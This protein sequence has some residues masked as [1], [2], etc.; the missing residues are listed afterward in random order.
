M[1]RHNLLNN[2]VVRANDIQAPDGVECEHAGECAGHHFS[3]GNSIVDAMAELDITGNVIP[4]TWFQSIK[5]DNGKPNI[6]ACLILSEIVYWYRPKVIFDKAS[7]KK[8]GIEKRFNADLLQKSYDDFAVKFGLSKDQARNAVQALEKK[9]II[10]KDFRTINWGGTKVANVLFIELFVD[11]LIEVTYPNG[12][13]S[14]NR[15]R[16]LGDDGEGIALKEDTYLLQTGYPYDSVPK[17]VSS[18]AHTNTK[19]TAEINTKIT[20]TTEGTVNPS[21]II[22]EDVVVAFAEELGEFRLDDNSIRAIIRAADG[23]PERVKKAIAL[24]KEQSQPIRNIPGWLIRA[25][26]EGYT[27][28]CRRQNKFGM[29]H[30]FSEKALSEIEKKLLT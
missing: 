20:T 7:G 9:G 17:G 12:I 6:N 28:V 30:C 8:T 19:N 15:R 5:Y 1:K 3:S 24:L 22:R 16:T 13:G 11:K 2:T 27:N 4:D 23:E 18:K 10:A 29:S 26:K 25:L 14:N 21:E